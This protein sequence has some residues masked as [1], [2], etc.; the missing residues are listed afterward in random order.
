MKF[1]EISLTVF[2]NNNKKRYKKLKMKWFL[3]LS[4]LTL[5]RKW[6]LN[7]EYLNETKKAIFERNKVPAK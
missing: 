6:F 5:L 1:D 4:Y 7:G 3:F 2:D